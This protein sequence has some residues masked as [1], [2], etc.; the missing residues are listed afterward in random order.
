MCAAVHTEEVGEG[1]N[2][3]AIEGPPNSHTPASNWLC[4]M[5]PNGVHTFLTILI[6]LSCT[7]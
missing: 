3:T 2:G 7:N 6:T 5:V 4:F 1:V